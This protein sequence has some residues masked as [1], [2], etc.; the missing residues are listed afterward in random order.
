MI[1]G[2]FTDLEVETVAM[3]MVMEMFAPHELPVPDDI[4]DKYCA[5]ARIALDAAER[6]G[7]E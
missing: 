7:D 5:T 4:W 2:P 6:A 1:R 3:A